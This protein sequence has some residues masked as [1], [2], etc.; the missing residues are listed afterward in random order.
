[1][2]SPPLILTLK[3][4]RAAFDRLNDLRQRHFPPA[5]NFLPAHITLFHALPG[6]QAETIERH[7]ETVCAQTKLIKL[8]FPTVR[9]LGKGVAAEIDAPDLLHLHQRL[10]ADWQIWLTRQDQQKYRPHV[11]IQ[12]KV[13]PEEAKQL[14]QELAASWKQSEAIGEGLLLWRYLNGPWELAREFAFCQD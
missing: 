8:K 14:Y 11:T 4:D 12:N 6:D 1:M 3:L 7:L 5:R 9:S 2:T 13:S 10:A